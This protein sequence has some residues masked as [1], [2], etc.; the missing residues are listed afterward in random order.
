MIKGG[1]NMTMT[2]RQTG[3]RIG[4]CKEPPRS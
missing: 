1:K 2:E 4:T 3:R